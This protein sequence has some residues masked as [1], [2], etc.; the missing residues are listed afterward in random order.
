MNRTVCTRQH[1]PSLHC[2]NRSSP[3]NLDWTDETSLNSGTI[4]QWLDLED[5][6]PRADGPRTQLESI[7]GVHPEAKI[8]LPPLRTQQPVRLRSAARALPLQSSVVARGR[9][10]QD[11]RTTR[12]RKRPRNYTR[13]GRGPTCR[14]RKAWRSPTLCLPVLQ[15]CGEMNSAQVAGTN[16]PAPAPRGTTR[17]L[18]GR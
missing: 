1:S 5:T 3:S 9:E 2:S 4:T 7:D 8:I 15:F 17:A 16:Q 12:N 13:N 14:H 11:H 6:N 10:Q 18:P